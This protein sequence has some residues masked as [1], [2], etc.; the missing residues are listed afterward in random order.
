M[1]PTVWAALSIGV[2]ISLGNAN[3][4]ITISAAA[5]RSTGNGSGQDLTNINSTVTGS[6]VN[7]ISGGDTT[8]RGG[9]VSGNTVTAIVG[10]NLTIESP[11]DTSSY[12][13]TGS[14]A[15]FGISYNI[16]TGAVSG[17]L[18][19]GSTQINSTLNSVGT[20]SA[21]NAGNGGFYVDVAGNTTLTGGAITSSQTAVNNNANFFATQGTL[22]VTDI[23]NSASF[24][25]NQTAVSVG[26]GPKP[27]GT[28]GITGGGGLGNASGNATSVTSSGISGIAGNTAVRTGDTE[29]GLKP[30]FNATAVRADVGG[31]TVVSS[32]FGPAATNA[33]GTY[34]D[35]QAKDPNKT[36]AERKCWEEGQP[37][38]VA[39]HAVIGGLT[40]GTGGAV[41]AATSQTLIPLVGAALQDQDIPPLVRD[42][43]VA[44]LGAV[45]G[46]A[47][48]GTA[49]AVAGG[50]ATVNNYLS[51]PERNALDAARKS[52]YA[53]QP[54]SEACKT[55]TRLN[56][57]DQSRDAQL[58]NLIQNCSG[59]SC[60]DA[61]NAIQAELNALGCTGPR[62]CDDATLNRAWQDAKRKSQGLEGIYPEEWAALTAGLVSGTVRLG[63]GVVALVRSDGRVVIADGVAAGRGGFASADGAGA[64]LARPSTTIPY[65]PPGSMVLQGTQPVCGPACAAMTITD[66]TGISVS[67]DTVI[68]NFPNGVRITGVNANEISTVIT[69]AGVANRVE[70]AILPS[71]LNQALNGG[72][73]VILNTGNHFIIIDSVR[74]V[75]GVTYYMTR[76]PFMGPRGV[77]ASI[78]DARIVNGAN[79]IVIGR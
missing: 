31:Q 33:W 67:L 65:E 62:V 68:G 75:N 48:G 63:R 16:V 5:N 20:Q 10:G 46:G 32:A 77:A 79:A 57:L 56:N 66:R 24:N 2:G 42:L 52:C 12:K 41:G 37:C 22:T 51:D 45:I 27:G 70:R 40:G 72:Q 71:E 8:I 38:R 7:L 18:S 19:A 61:A 34:S 59:A 9:V 26:Y 13:E 58:A 25:A 43:I 6:S 39:G 54:D 28:S 36:P 21:I 47:T 15:G 50:N 64:S 1:L 69:N 35:G 17:S 4:G 14:T 3:S 11:I 53:A 74:V 30:I 44:G 76:D 60:N 23:V 49:G 55:V 78:L 29:T 73:T